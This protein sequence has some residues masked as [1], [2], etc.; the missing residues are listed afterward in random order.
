MTEKE[1]VLLLSYQYNNRT[2]LE[3]D[4][5]Q[6]RS[7]LRYRDVD[8]VDCMELMLAIERLNMFNKVFRDVYAI[9]KI[10][11]YTDFDENKI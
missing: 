10:R 8:S 1:K 4:V 11:K 2:Y 5:V 9:L 7:N 3:R 6:L